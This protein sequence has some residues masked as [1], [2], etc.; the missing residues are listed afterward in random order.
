MKR[1]TAFA[2]TTI[3]CG[4]SL[5]AG[6]ALADTYTFGD[7]WVNWGNLPEYN[8]NLGDEYGNPHIDSMNVTVENNRLTNVTITGSDRETFDTLF[9]NT[10]Y[11]GQN[12]QEWNY[13]VRD[14]VQN[15]QQNGYG[16]GQANNGLYTVDSS[17]TYTTAQNGNG[18]SVRVGNPNG[19]H[20][21]DLTS[22]SL[23][24]DISASSE[25]GPFTLSYDFADGGLELDGGFYVG[26]SPWC[27]NDVIGGGTTTSP[28]PEPAT[29]LLFGTG[30]AGLAGLR[31]KKMKA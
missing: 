7:T 8:T 16:P 5:L 14:G 6:N 11:T 30:L 19:I 22:A 28:V 9:I 24:Y 1:T 15:N 3:F 10:S 21:D 27:A 17:Y 29:M 25:E 18:Y 26:Y 23:D 2:A 31:R 13:L 4:V 12:W 20:A